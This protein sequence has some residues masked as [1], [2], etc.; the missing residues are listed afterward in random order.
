[1]T[2][3]ERPPDTTG[4]PAHRSWTSQIEALLESSRLQGQPSALEGPT[5]PPPAWTPQAA[6]Q[7]AGLVHAAIADEVAQATTGLRRQL[8]DAHRARTE[9]C[10]ELGQLRDAIRLYLAELVA[11]GATID[12]DDANAVLRGWTIDPLPARFTVTLNATIAATVVADD[13]EDAAAQA[14]RMLEDLARDNADETVT[15][16][17]LHTDEVVELDELPDPATRE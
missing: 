17:E 3:P 2:E 4:P 11:S 16:T 9:S 10:S 5:W 15:I 14:H 12:R 13:A 7:L 6:H 8:D 1:M